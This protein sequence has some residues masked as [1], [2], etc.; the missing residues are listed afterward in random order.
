MARDETELPMTVRFVHIG[1]SWLLVAAA[2]AFSAGC[3]DGRDEIA[4]DAAIQDARD[5]SGPALEAAAIDV[6]VDFPNP[7]LDA[8]TETNPDADHAG[9]G[10]RDAVNAD[11]S[12]LSAGDA[13]DEDGAD[14]FITDA[15]DEDGA[16]AGCACTPVDAGIKR[17]SLDCF[18]NT[19]C[20]SLDCFPGVC[21]TYE[22][23]LRDP[24]A[25]FPF[26]TF[27]GSVWL[28][29]YDDGLTTVSRYVLDGG[30]TTLIFDAM[31]KTLVGAQRSWFGVPWYSPLLCGEKS[32]AYPSILYFT[33]RAG[34]ELAG[35]STA[36]R[37]L[38]PPPD[39]G[40]DAAPDATTDGDAPPD[41]TA[42]REDGAYG[43]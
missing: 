31:T 18:C 10:A 13:A 2:C 6:A 14:S 35:T 24:C 7:E 34:R 25:G 11:R 19:P 12:D 5:A 39:G 28:S 4:P 32:D 40:P 38:C 3:N 42:D 1:R 43:D 36:G 17:I 30:T 22:D 15:A 27:P 23:I 21:A 26:P 16:D 37:Q 41:T 20:P 33:V 29:T 8:S 9:D